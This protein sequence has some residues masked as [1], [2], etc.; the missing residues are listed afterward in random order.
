MGIEAEFGTTSVQD[1]KAHVKY[2]KCDDVTTKSQG[3]V[4]PL[5]VRLVNFASFCIIPREPH[6]VNINSKTQTMQ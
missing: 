1:G 6:C 2:D 4:S 5:S 3:L